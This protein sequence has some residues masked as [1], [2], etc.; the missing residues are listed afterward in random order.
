MN[1]ALFA[2]SLGTFA[3]GI[4]EFVMMGILVNIAGSFHISVSQAGHFISSYAIGVCVGA[5]ALLKVRR[6]PLKR[7]ML[8]LSAII[9][10]GN[11]CAAAAPGFW[12]LM[13]ARFISGLPHGAF[14]GVGAIVARKLARPGHEVQAV[15]LMIAGMTVANL[16]GVPLGTWLA[17]AF[18][19]R[20]AFLVAGASGGITLLLVR[21]WLPYM[22]PLPD[23]G[24]KG[25]FR[26]LRTLPPWLIF[27]GVFIGQSG[28]YCWY[29]YIDPLL[30]RVSGFS[31]SDLTWLMLVA[32]TGMFAG[33]IIAG[34]LSTRFKPSLVAAALQ[35]SA[36][37]L[38]VLIYF[39]AE[40]KWAMVV[41]TFLCTMAMFGTGSPLQSSIVAYSKGGEMLGAALIQIGYNAGNAIAAAV[42]GSVIHAGHGYSAPCLAGM[43]FVAVGTVMLFTLYF[44]RERGRSVT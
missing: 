42:G 38:L 18:S 28:I 27:G 1:K 3:L 17:N 22:E 44:K 43:P 25:Q 7:I 29:S 20:L 36:M 37:L 13:A 4:A 8:M 19:W 30:T 9:C 6:Y 10:A 23:T 41:L 12:P 21:L 26:F 15:S 35:A 39:T 16:F 24:L 5:L 2:L 14:F 11:L 33:N 31:A 34:P 32:G 40:I